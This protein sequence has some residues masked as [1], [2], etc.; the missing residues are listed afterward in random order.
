[1]SPLLEIRN[2]RTAFPGA[3][4]G[5]GQRE[6]IHVVDDVSFDLDRGE[7]LALVGEWRFAPG[8]RALFDF[9]GLAAPQGRAI[10][11]TLQ[12]G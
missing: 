12:A 11:A 1:M 4:S 9:E 7:V 8:W 2:L 3:R 6:R 5:I 10:D